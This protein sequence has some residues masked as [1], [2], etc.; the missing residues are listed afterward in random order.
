MLTVKCFPNGNSVH[1]DRANGWYHVN[2]RRWNGELI[3]KIRCDDY[4]D[5][6]AYRRAFCAIASKG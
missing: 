5:A 1:F 2:A 6:L 4:R 3:D